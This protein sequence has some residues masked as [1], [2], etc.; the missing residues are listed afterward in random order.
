MKLDDLHPSLVQA[1]CVSLPTRDC[2]ALSA[3]SRR[4][5]NALLQPCKLWNSVN[6]E[7]ATVPL[8]SDRASRKFT[9][10][11]RYEG[12]LKFSAPKFWKLTPEN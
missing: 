7:A 11:A 9:S 6:L 12:G 4:L 5:S 10:L 3:T 2:L 1:I 8:D